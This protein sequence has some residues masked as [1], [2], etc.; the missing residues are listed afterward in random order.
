MLIEE[1]KWSNMKL[2]LIMI[3]EPIKK[4]WGFF[5]NF[6]DIPFFFFLFKISDINKEGLITNLIKENQLSTYSNKVDHY[7]WSITI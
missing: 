4:Y 3:L 6:M 2:G 7:V 5:F 1:M